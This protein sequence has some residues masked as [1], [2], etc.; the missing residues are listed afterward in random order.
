MLIFIKSLFNSFKKKEKLSVK[1][2]IAENKSFP[3]KKVSAEI[4]HEYGVK[5]DI[6][7]MRIG[8]GNVG[9]GMSFSPHMYY[10]SRD[11]ILKTP[12]DYP[13]DIVKYAKTL[14]DEMIK[15]EMQHERMRHSTS[16][17]CGTSRRRGKSSS[18]SR[19]SSSSFNI[20]IHS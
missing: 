9:N 13:D 18:R 12:S 7:M 15:K 4:M 5:I 6:L 1:E 10:S 8:L 17:E 16:D 20:D 2:L 11:R 3:N 14:T 19:R